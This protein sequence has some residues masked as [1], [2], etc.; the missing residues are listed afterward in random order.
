M[1]FRREILHSNAVG[2]QYCV[3]TDGEGNVNCINGDA[4]IAAYV[5]ANTDTVAPTSAKF[6]YDK[7]LPN[8][9]LTYNFNPA[10][11][12]FA[13]YAMNLSVPSTDALYGAIYTGEAPIAETSDSF[14]AG[15][16]YLL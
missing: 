11:S 2:D 15:V 5:A 4:D 13:S 12:V 9:G 3:T 1:A 16:R 8:V 7:L 14:D 6:K 10:F